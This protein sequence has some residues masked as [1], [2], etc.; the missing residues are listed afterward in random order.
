MEFQVTVQLVGAGPG[1]ADLLT[2]RAARAIAAAEVVVFDRLVD[3]SVLELISPLADR[4]DVGKTPGQSSSQESTNE[5]L[6]ELGR[7]G[8]RVVRLKGGDPFVFGRGGEEA[9]ALTSAGVAFEIIPGLSSSLSG[10]LAAGIPVTHRGI[11]R[12]VTIV[13]GHLIDGECNS[14][15]HLANPELT[16][17]VLMGVAHRAEIAR[18]LILGGLTPDT[19]VA[20]IE[21]AYTSSQRTVRTSLQRLG[22]TEIANPAIIVI[23]AVAAMSL[24]DI[25]TELATAAW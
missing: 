11:S 2:V 24:N 3:R 18:Q 22:V 15:V 20:V 5:L 16:L 25:T 12:G 23:G 21:R 9:L 4:Y 13:T 8:R 10:P 7:S 14:F 17:V 1:E 19:P 6:I